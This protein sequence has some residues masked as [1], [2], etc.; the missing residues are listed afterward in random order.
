M[1]RAG[2]VA[3]IGIGSNSVRMLIVERDEHS[4]YATAPQRMEGVTRLAG[5]ALTDGG[6]RLQDK[7]MDD[8]VGVAASFVRQARERGA[9]L[10]GVIATE[11][12]RAASNRDELVARLEGELGLPVRIIS[13]EEEARLGWRAVASAASMQHDSGVALGVI[14]IGGGSTDL[15]A[16]FVDAD[17]P[18]SV[19]S[20]QMG[21][22][23][24]MQRFGLD[25]PIELSKL[26]G[27]LAA[28]SIEIAPQAASLDPKPEIAV[29]IGGTAN[30]LARVSQALAVNASAG[31]AIIERD[32]L[33]RWV[34]RMSLLD[35]AGRVAQGVPA[36]RADV[37][38]AGAVILLSLLEAWGIQQFSVCERNI[39]D[40]F[41]MSYEL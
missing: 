2:L 15:S 7:A 20:I 22:R 16:G 25:R 35:K 9:A 13:G 1:G 23:T 36:D 11:A 14:D 34:P 37:I 12:V 31:D 28:V 27:T 10:V 29:V 30:V 19:V 41:L 4:G 18:Q 17:R 32:W 8:T 3:V 38:V 5:Y 26:W 33:A 6:Y 24:A 40:G 21:S 39:L